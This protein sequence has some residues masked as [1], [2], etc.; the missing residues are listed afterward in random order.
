MVAISSSEVGRVGRVE[1]EG[2]GLA[3]RSDMSKQIVPGGPGNVRLA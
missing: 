2:S 3:S 1:R